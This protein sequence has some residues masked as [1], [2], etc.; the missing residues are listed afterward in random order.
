M[1]PTY[2]RRLTREEYAAVAE[3]ALFIKSMEAVLTQQTPEPP[4]DFGTFQGDDQC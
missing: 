3:A 1:E 2:G 4:S